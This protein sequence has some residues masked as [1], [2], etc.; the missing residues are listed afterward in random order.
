MS[1]WSCRQNALRAPPPERRI[2]RIGRPR[3]RRI[4]TAS[5]MAKVAPSM[6]RADQFVARRCG[7]VMPIQQAAGVAG[8]RAGVRSPVR[9]GSQN[10]PSQPA[11]AAAAWAVSSS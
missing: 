7:G 11:G 9:Y 5:F 8:R 3:S 6:H 1:A 4:V 10:S 2:C